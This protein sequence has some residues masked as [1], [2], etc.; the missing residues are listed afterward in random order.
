MGV[1]MA[2]AMPVKMVFFILFLSLGKWNP[3]NLKAVEIVIKGC[4]LFEKVRH[5]LQQ[6]RAEHLRAGV[7]VPGAADLVLPG[8]EGHQIFVVRRFGTFIAVGIH[9]ITGCFLRCPDE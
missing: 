6:F 3:S 2:V 5:F 9:F 4:Q 7:N 1:T 8:K